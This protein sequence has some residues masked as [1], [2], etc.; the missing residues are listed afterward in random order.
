M[1]SGTRLGELQEPSQEGSP[2]VSTE[3]DALSQCGQKVGPESN[4]QASGL[5]QAGLVRLCLSFPFWVEFCLKTEV[6]VGWELH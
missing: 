4:H 2:R 3:A 5:D 1:E 6:G